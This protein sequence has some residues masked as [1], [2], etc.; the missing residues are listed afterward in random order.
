MG[1][2]RWTESIIQVHHLR[3]H[4]KSHT[5]VH[6]FQSPAQWIAQNW[7]SVFCIHRKWEISPKFHGNGR[8][9]PWAWRRQCFGRFPA[10][11]RLR[12][13]PLAVVSGSWWMLSWP[14][15]KTISEPSSYS[16]AHPELI[17]INK[18][19][20]NRAQIRCV[21]FFMIDLLATVFTS[22]ILKK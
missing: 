16:L 12:L 20:S 15:C 13:L 11:Q 6:W 21:R 5:P 7:I 4:H 19:R 3:L 1:C 18:S 9:R 14:Y 8:N 22:I 2:L 10:A 17:P